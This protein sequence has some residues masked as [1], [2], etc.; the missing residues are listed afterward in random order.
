MAVKE[1]EKEYPNLTLEDFDHGQNVRY[2]P[3]HANGDPTHEDCENGMV[4]SKNDS[5]IFV[6][7]IKNGILQETAQ[8]TKPDQLMH[9][10]WLQGNGEKNGTNGTSDACSSSSDE[11]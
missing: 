11:E 6:R 1:Q 10:H 7:Y 5:F 9:G 3:Y 4:K 8:A 2:I